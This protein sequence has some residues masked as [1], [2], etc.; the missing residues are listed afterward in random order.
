[1]GQHVLRISHWFSPKSTSYRTPSHITTWATSPPLDEDHPV[2]GL[3]V[4]VPFAHHLSCSALFSK[5]NSSYSPRNLLGSRTVSL[6]FCRETHVGMRSSK[7]R[8]LSPLTSVDPNIKAIHIIM[9][10]QMIFSAQFGYFEYVTCLPHGITWPF[11][12]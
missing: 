4:A 7:S 5:F 12:S 1:M 6:C 8:P 2:E 11:L 3:L 10:V 9:Q